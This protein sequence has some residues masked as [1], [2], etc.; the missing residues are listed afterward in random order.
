MSL[1]GVTVFATLFF[2]LYCLYFTV[3]IFKDSIYN[4]SNPLTYLTCRTL[5]IVLQGY[6]VLV[7][8]Y[9]TLLLNRDHLVRK[10]SKHITTQ[11]SLRF[12]I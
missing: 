12:T 4:V 2:Q 10:L 11:T 6:F 3:D 9:L 5:R 1:L 7:K 8:S